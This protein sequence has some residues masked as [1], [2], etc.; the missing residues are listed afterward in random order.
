MTIKKSKQLALVNSNLIVQKT[1]DADVNNKRIIDYL[2]IFTFLITFTLMSIFL[3][4]QM[5]NK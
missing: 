2:I 5:N 3:H 1:I 4:Y